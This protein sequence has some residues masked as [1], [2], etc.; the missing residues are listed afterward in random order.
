MLEIMFFVGPK[1]A[2]NCFGGCLLVQSWRNA[3][4]R[5]RT[6]TRARA[7]ARACV[8]ARARAR[9]R[10]LGKHKTNGGAN[11][12]DMKKRTGALSQGFANG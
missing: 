3:R 9:A 2:K 5:A 4:T 12:K 10:E 11:N 8:R 7:R 1:L 6:R